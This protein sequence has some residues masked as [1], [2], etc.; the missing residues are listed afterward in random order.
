MD[1][2]G[3]NLYLSFSVVRHVLMSLEGKKEVLRGLGCQ[4]LQGEAAGHAVVGKIQLGDSKLTSIEFQPLLLGRSLWVEWSHPILVAKAACTYV[5]HLL[6]DL[7]DTHH[8]EAI[9][10]FLLRPAYSSPETL[11]RVS[12][13]NAA[14]CRIVG[15]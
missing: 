13:E 14:P 9:D 10:R 15:R 12:V 4:T 3:E 2:L 11:F 1:K 7:R 8:Q 6:L 5:D